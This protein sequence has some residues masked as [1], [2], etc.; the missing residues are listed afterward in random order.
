MWV[1]ACT[2]VCVCLRAG[3]QE[4]GPPRPAPVGSITIT[5][6]GGFCLIDALSQGGQGEDS[7]LSRTA[8]VMVDVELQ[9]SWVFR[10][11]VVL[12]S[13]IDEITELQ[14]S[15]IHCIHQN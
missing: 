11:S 13:H 1:C 4:L 2:C 9:V 8:R 5:V 12:V 3:I 15:Q 7:V 14:T 6:P 10:N